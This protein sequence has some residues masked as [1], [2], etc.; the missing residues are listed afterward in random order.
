MSFKFFIKKFTQQ[1]L[2]DYMSEC[3][4]VCTNFLILVEKLQDIILSSDSQVH[5]LNG[6]LSKHKKKWHDVEQ[7]TATEAKS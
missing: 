6:V 5:P 4:V 3:C 2:S 7:L 1:S